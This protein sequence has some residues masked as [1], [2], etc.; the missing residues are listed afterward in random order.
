MAVVIN[1]NDLNKL[2][3]SAIAYLKGLESEKLFI[4][5]DSYLM[6]GSDEWYDVVKE[7]TGD[8]GS[9]VDDWDSLLK[10]IHNEEP[11]SSLDLDR[12]AAILKAISERINPI[13]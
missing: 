4:E 7:N 8:I 11:F 3:G 6:I 9:L 5:Q 13:G 1:V 2:F 10:K 12:L